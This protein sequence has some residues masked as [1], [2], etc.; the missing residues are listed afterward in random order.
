MKEISDGM[1]NEV[2]G[3]NLTS[4]ILDFIMNRGADSNS[5]QGEWHSNSTIESPALGKGEE[6]GKAIVVGGLTALAVAGIAAATA[7]GGV[8]QGIF[9][10]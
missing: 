7:F 1:L 9:R 2:S 4:S 10:R 5:E 8:F 6:Y 3:G